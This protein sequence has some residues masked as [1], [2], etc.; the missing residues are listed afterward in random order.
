MGEAWSEG[1]AFGELRSVLGGP[2]GVDAFE[3][4]LE[5]I[6][7]A[8]A[9]APGLYAA[10]WRDYVTSHLKGWP[11]ADRRVRVSAS[12]Q[13]EQWRTRPAAGLV[14]S[15]VFRVFGPGEC[16]DPR[17]SSHL[18]GN[19]ELGAELVRAQVSK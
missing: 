13:I 14:R 4:V 3:R 11:D 16:S 8:E 12:S 1:E 9:A 17:K 18:S 7:R 19:V 15:V 10:R 6:R 5:L 2:P